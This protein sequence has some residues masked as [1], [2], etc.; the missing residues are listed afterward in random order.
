MVDG[1]HGGDQ[2]EGGRRKSSQ[3]GEETSE[4]LGEGLPPGA[5]GNHRIRFRRI[6]GDG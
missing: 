3:G 6:S 5:A 2:G 4:Q 1:S